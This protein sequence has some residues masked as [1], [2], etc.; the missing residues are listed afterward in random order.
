MKRVFMLGA[1][2]SVL[3]LTLTATAA[4]AAENDHSYYLQ[5]PLETGPEVTAQCL[6]CHEKHA[7]DFMKTT[8][9]NWA[10]LLYTS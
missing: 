8:H 5:G 10:C 4:L 3:L 1:L 7:T 9:W 6:K 2:C